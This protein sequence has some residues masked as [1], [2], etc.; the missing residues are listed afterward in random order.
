[1]V[2]S[3]QRTS[4]P[5]PKAPE[6]SPVPDSLDSNQRKVTRAESSPDDA[7][8][9]VNSRNATNQKTDLLDAGPPGEVS[10]KTG[11]RSNLVEAPGGSE[12]DSDVEDP[13][14]EGPVIYPS[15]GNP[16]DEATNTEKL[17]NWDMENAIHDNCHHTS[18]VR[19]EWMY[20]DRK[21]GKAFIRACRR[22]SYAAYP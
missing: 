18:P 4:P 20:E 9:A 8:G 12:H 15:S 17:K 21:R 6:V 16:W 10:D 5:S 13:E 3:H 1:M 14:T 7:T 11:E 19:T 2:P 22:D